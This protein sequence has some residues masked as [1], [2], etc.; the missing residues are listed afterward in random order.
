MACL[1]CGGTSGAAMDIVHS[2]VRIVCAPH[3]VPETLTPRMTSDGVGLHTT[4]P[5]ITTGTLDKHIC[6]QSLLW[7]LGFGYSIWSS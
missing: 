1:L 6:L 2:Q 3:G 4:L 7:A 5:P